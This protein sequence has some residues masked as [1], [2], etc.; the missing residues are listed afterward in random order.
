MLLNLNAIEKGS[1]K[2]SHSGKFPVNNY[3]KYIIFILNSLTNHINYHFPVS[4]K[5]KGEKQYIAAKCNSV[6]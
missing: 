4:L 1:V 3:S 2:Y 6:N 5:R